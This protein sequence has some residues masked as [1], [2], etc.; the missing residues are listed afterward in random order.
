MPVSKLTGDTGLSQRHLS[1]KFQQYVGLSPKE[2]LRVC[3]FIRSLHHLK[4]Y[5][6]LSLTE[7]A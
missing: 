2:Y 6:L 4:K 5:P 1:R 3:R 7:V